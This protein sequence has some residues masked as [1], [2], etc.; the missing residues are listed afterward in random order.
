MI[1]YSEL[2]ALAIYVT[3]LLVVALC[4]Y[5]GHKTAS[6]FLIGERSLNFYLTAFAAHASD[7]SS[8]LFMGFPAVIFL[9]GL[10]NAWLAIGL[11][12][13]MF[14]N[15]LLIAPR[16]RIQT[17]KYNSLTF[18][19]FFE[20]HFHDT[21]GLI[22]VFTAIISLIFYTIYISAG[23]VGLGLLIKTL[24]GV[25]YLIGITLGMLV[26]IPYLFIG[27]YRTLAW[28]DSFQGVFLMLVIVIVPLIVLPKIGG[29]A[30]ISDALTTY[31][32]TK[33]LIPNLK[34][35]T[36]S[37]IFLGIFGWGIG[38][39]GQPHIITKFMGIKKASDMRKSMIVGMSWQIITLTFATLIG[40]IAV[41]YFKGSLKNPELA[42]I[43]IVK[44]T[45]SPG[46]MA[47]ILCAI[48]AA[49]ISTMDSQILVLAST[50]TEDIYKRIFRK[51]ASSKELLWISRL[52]I[53]IVS[54]ISYCIAF[55]KISTIYSLVFYAW[56]GLGA[57]FG[58][59]LLFS[60]YSKKANKYGVWAGLLTGGTTAIIY[61]LINTAIS[62]LIPGFLLG[63]LAIYFGSLLTR[64][65]ALS[66]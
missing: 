66:S 64:K 44:H 38:Y 33:D 25:P 62:P 50:L 53:L 42:F 3:I 35:D 18:S 36:L 30:G 48:L 21:S 13:F 47:F 8:W 24:F 60:L 65:R 52:F 32:L 20:S 45:F 37:Q 46:I 17:E 22:R 15:W 34:F 49:I 51:T 39:F 54:L 28:L 9:G 23:I 12:F 58:P 59:L 19:S 7:M 57:A 5:R 27:G 14:L 11:V 43:L 29:F 61:P 10:F 31:Q 2:G 6:D 26:V 40:L 55:F 63:V 16:I 41:A 1:P 4:S 56:S